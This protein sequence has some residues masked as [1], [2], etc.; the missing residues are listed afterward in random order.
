MNETARNKCSRCKRPS[1][2]EMRCCKESLCKKCFIELFE[3]RVR[4]TIRTNRLLC[5]SGRT[6]VA[7]S[8]GKDSAVTLCILKDILKKAPQSKLVAVTIDQGIKGSEKCLEV[9]KR[10]C[11]E[12]N[13]EHRIYSF[14]EE[15][16][17]TMD[18]A[19][20][21]MGKTANPPPACSFCGVLRRKLLNAKAKELGA[22]RIATGHN[23]DDEIQTGLMNYVRGDVEKIARMG[24]LVG[25]VK[26]IGFVQR[27]KPLRDSP[28][29]E[30][31]LYAQLKGIEYEPS[32]CPYSGDAFRG[33]IR[34]AIGEIEEKHPG[35]KFQILKSTD[36][37][38]KLLRDNID[39]GVIGKCDK[40]G[41][42]CSGG[43]CNFCR[44]EKN[45]KGDIK[46]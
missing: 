29:N 42:P 13:V 30:V 38:I 10:L 28:E 3:K 14:K 5:G 2:Y 8:G 31:L 19:V 4:R 43:I 35:S 41:D 32:R 18:E 7:L 23:M 27:I 26:D 44:I 6:A 1:V 17:C 46:S 40:C 39:F 34:K 33:T 9:S 15:Y 36:H 25:I 22:T 21:K 45:I 20:K 12:L 37:L 16:D 24:A 11:R